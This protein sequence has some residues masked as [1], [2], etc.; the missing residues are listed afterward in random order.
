M[1]GQ[2]LL[3]NRYS[4]RHSSKQSNFCVGIGVDYSNNFRM[5]SL[6]SVH[7]EQNSVVFW[8]KPI[9]KFENLIVF[10]R[11]NTLRGDIL[12]PLML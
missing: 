3:L 1:R 5:L 2:V 8:V 9:Y 12:K 6:Y 4:T 10:A 7:T 11:L